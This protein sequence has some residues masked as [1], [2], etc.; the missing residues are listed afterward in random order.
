M[1][2]IMESVPDRK[3]VTIYTDGGCDPNPGPGGYGVV[4]LHAGKR[5]ELA[6]GFRLTTNNRMELLAA[7]T[8]LAALR[9]RCEVTLHSDS[10]YLVDAMARGWVRSW[11]ARGWRRAGQGPIANRDLW[12]RLI[13]LT[14]KHEVAFRWVRGHA[15]VPENERC[16]ELAA[17]GRLGGDLAVDAGYL[18]AANQRAASERAGTLFGS[19]PAISDPPEVSTRAPVRAPVPGSGAAITQEGQPCRKCGTPV[20]RRVPGRRK[21]SGKLYVYEYYLFCLACKTMYMVDS[22]KVSPIELERRA[23]EEKLARR[24][25][26]AARPV[27]SRPGALPVASAHPRVVNRIYELVM[28]ARADAA[29]F[30]ELSLQLGRDLGARLTHRLADALQSCQD[31]EMA[32]LKFRLHLHPESGVTLCVRGKRNRNALIALADRLRWPASRA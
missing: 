10:R 14:G 30:E 25:P 6:G 19:D 3:Q 29:M 17:R 32:G 2:D 11:Q 12:E 15:G 26:P 9:T 22:A 31:F 18:E 8:G 24:S 27:A 13:E 28:S 16:D 1:L 7:I 4:L 21:N 5:R 20:V 23:F